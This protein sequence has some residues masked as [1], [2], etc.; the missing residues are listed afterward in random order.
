MIRRH[1]LATAAFTLILLTCFGTFAVGQAPAPR[2]RPRA[3]VPVVNV[4]IPETMKVSVQRTVPVEARIGEVTIKKMPPEPLWESN[5][6]TALGSAVVAI[7][8]VFLAQWRRDVAEKKRTKARLVTRIRTALEAAATSLESVIKC[9][10]FLCPN[11]ID[12][13]SG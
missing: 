11:W 7:L 2:N 6:A 10:G 8:V 1:T 5:L 12:G 3:G 13:S 9:V 4:T